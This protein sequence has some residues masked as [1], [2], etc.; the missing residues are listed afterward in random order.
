MLSASYVAAAIAMC[1]AVLYLFFRLRLFLTTTTMLVGSLLL[2]YGPAYLSFMLSSGEFAFLTRQLS[3]IATTPNSMF[4]L[5]KGKIADFDAVVIAMNFSIALMYVSVIAGI[6]I[7]DRLIQQRIASLRSALRGWGSQPLKDDEGGGKILLGMISGLALFMFFVSFKENHIATI[8]EFLFST[9][10]RVHYRVHHGGSPNY[11]YRVVLTAI[12]PMFVIW[13]LL[14][15]WLNRSWPLLLSAAL[16]FFAVFIGKSETLSKAPPAFFLIQLMVAFSLAFTNKITLRSTLIGACV[17]AALFYA[18]MRLVVITPEGIGTLEAV[19]SR[20]F[21]TESQSLLENFATFP[22]MHP[23]M[24]GTNIRPVSMLLGLHYIPGF[25]IAAYTWYGTYDITS[26]SLFI[27]DAWTDFS[28]AGVIVYSVIAG[29]VCRSIDASFLV[30]G[31]TVVGV[32]VL[33]ATFLGIFT[34]LTTAL[35]IAFFSG[36]LLLAPVLAGI[37]VTMT[38]YFEGRHSMSPAAESGGKK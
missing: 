19:Y 27:A 11:L 34:L 21:E 17:V 37:L 33:G 2:I 24:W 36:G 7:V 32:A 14:A 8:N 5:M 16:L 23:F 22:F 20:V 28:Y 18:V 12:A 6:E 35:N 10:D 13:G 9:P 31:K 38:R 25:S 3:G 29:A 15:G 1:I 26:P 4:R 30:Q